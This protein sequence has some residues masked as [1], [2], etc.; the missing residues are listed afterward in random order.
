MSRISDLA[1]GVVQVIAWAIAGEALSIPCAVSRHYVPARTPEEIEASAVALVSVVP[2]SSSATPFDR[3]RDARSITIDIGIQSKAGEELAEIDPL[4]DLV[5][6]I[7]A[8]FWRKTVEGWKVAEIRNDPIYVPAHLID[9]RI[10]TAVLS[11]R[12]DAWLAGGGA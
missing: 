2:R 7:E 4:A 3:A 11:I 1:D 8:L 9:S 6:E 12:F 10:F 5:E